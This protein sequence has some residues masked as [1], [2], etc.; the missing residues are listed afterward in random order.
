MT[1]TARRKSAFKCIAIVA[2]EQAAA[3]QDPALAKTLKTLLK[4]LEG[5]K[6]E[7]VLH[8]SAAKLGIGK[9]RQQE[10]ETGTY[11]TIG[12]RC[13]IAIVIGGDGTLLAAA[14]QFQDAGVP[15]LGINL[16]RL[17]FLA[18]ISPD[19]M[20]QALDAVLAGD[21]QTEKRLLL[22][23]KIYRGKKLI[24]ESRALNDVVIHT[25]KLPRML[26]FDTLIEGGFINSHRADGFIVS[27]PTG[28]TAYAL[29]GGGPV[30]HPGLEAIALVPICPH[31]LSDRPIVVPATC[32]VELRLSETQST[33]ALISFD[34]QHHLA[35]EPGDRVV[36]TRAHRRCRLIHPPDYD[37]FAILRNKLHWGSGT[38]RR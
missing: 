4:Q 21:Y 12:Q 14:R 38:D 22:R 17:G 37:Y 31:T 23:G 9:T 27:T 5:Y 25:R 36:I 24:D 1:E 35:L 11:Q 28:S 16:G 30:M 29:S 18:D 15:L 32:E 26:E 19:A 3:E 7:V 33:P 10:I 34:G 20:G 13:D 8:G 2:K 6:A